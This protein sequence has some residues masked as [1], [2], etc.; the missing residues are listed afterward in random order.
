MSKPVRIAKQ[1]QGLVM[2]CAALVSLPITAQTFPTKV[3]R[4][5]NAQGPGA[6]DGLARAYAQELTKYWGQPVIVEA[7]AG[8][9]SIVAADLVAKSSPDGYNILASSSA[10]GGLRIAEFEK[11]RRA[12]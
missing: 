10:A 11:E 4:I 5:I 6:L 8:A 3:V 2:M 1:L 7:R 12:M 9:G